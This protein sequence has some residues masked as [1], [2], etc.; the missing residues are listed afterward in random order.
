M[1]LKLREND[2]WKNPGEKLMSALSELYS[3]SQQNNGEIPG[4]AEAGLEDLDN[5]K[6]MV[7]S[8]LSSLGQ[9][10]EKKSINKKR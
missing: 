8:W 4:W 7:Q 6:Y 3:K 10:D 9:L 2:D 1:K 5:I